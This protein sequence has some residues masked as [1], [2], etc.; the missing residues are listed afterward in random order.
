MKFL[1]AA[2]LIVSSLSAQAGSVKG[3][4]EDVDNTYGCGD[5]ILLLADRWPI[6]EPTIHHPLSFEITYGLGDEPAFGIVMLSVAGGPKWKQ[7]WGWSWGQ[8]PHQGLPCNMWLLDLGIQ[9]PFHSLGPGG[10]GVGYALASIPDLPADLLKSTWY[11]QA[12]VITTPLDPSTPQ[13]LF[14]SQ[15]MRLTIGD[16]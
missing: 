10:I 14:M 3:S 7:V 8:P 2:L 16:K 9:V 4:H 5:C 12:A 1:L 6:S 11:A 13:I 15:A